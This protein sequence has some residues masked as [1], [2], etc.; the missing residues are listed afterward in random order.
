[1]KFIVL[2]LQVKPKYSRKCRKRFCN[3]IYHTLEHL[4][5]QAIDVWMGVCTAFVFAALVE[6]TF[7]NYMWRSESIS[8]DKRTNRNKKATINQ[9]HH[10]HTGF[11]RRADSFFPCMERQDSTIELDMVMIFLKS[12]L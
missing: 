9:R 4:S 3:Y 2:V 5:F 12:L 7:V 6:F 11:K 1:M 8:E 10:Q